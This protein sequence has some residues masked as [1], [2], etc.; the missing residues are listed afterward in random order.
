M[1]RHGCT[2]TK[3]EERTLRE[4]WAEGRFIREIAARLGRTYDSVKHCAMRLGLKRTPP[5]TDNRSGAQ[6]FPK[7]G[8]TVERTCLYGGHT[9]HAEVDENGRFI[10]RVCKPCK[11]TTDWRTSGSA[12]I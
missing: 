9:F 8:R 3:W 7:K 5:T 12:L 11:S 1:N 10:E 6:R 2:Y 4:M